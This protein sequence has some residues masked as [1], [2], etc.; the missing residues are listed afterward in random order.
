[1]AQL[2]STGQI[3]IVDTN[4]ARTIT[5]VLVANGATQQIYTKDES[6]VTYVPSWFTT[7]LVI[8][9]QIA[10]GGMTSAQTWAALSNK[11][12]ALTA[13]GAALTTA[14]TSA[15]FVNNSDVVVNTPF[16][17][18]HAAAGSSTPSTIAIA[19]NLKDSVAA[20]TLFFDADFVD[21]TTLLVTH[22]TCQITL[23]TVKT[24]TNA[25]FIT[26]RGQ[27]SIEE[28]TGSVKNNIAIAADLVRSS[29]I[30]TTNLTYK[31]YEDGGGVQITTSLASYATKYGLKT[32]SAGTVPTAT[33]TD[34]G[35]NIPGVGTGNAFNTLVINETAVAD[36]EIYKVE[37][38]DGDSKTYVAYFTIYDLSDPYEVRVLSST[39]DKL[40]N[41]QGST[42]LTPE[43][44]Y[45]ATKVSS[46]TDWSFTWFF[47]DRNG[48]R[49][50]FVDTAKISTAGGANISAN[51]TGNSAT[52]TY[53]GTSYAFTAGMIIKAVKPNGEAF[54]YEV[55]SSTTNSVTIRA[56]SINTWLTFV[57]YPAPSSTTDF[58]N[59]KLFGCTTGG[60]RTTINNNSITLTGDEV[61]SKARILVEAYRP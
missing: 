39:G 2:V 15:S 23:T 36:I 58:V 37:I 32:S 17:V 29:G 21:P 42:V 55:A 44:F 8:T 26:L 47:Y 41:G 45:G 51:T 28:A 56:P 48:K 50:A 33:G 12:F 16:V 60:T 18:T 46:L 43:V 35:V 6:T 59:G 9:P 40:Q 31:W 1:M 34:L 13:G 25:V 20:F 61:D 38:T 24:G 14:S 27:T 19:A 11:T 57:D 52:F 3:T 54:F 53:G 49:G 4:D 5:A 22:I 30:D 7:N 10:I